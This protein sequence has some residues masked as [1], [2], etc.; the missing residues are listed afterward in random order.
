MD[1]LN[2]PLD[3]RVALLDQAWIQTGLRAS[4]GAAG[5]S[6][7]K[8]AKGVALAASVLVVALARRDEC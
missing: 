6:G 8:G 4:G 7:V 3:G 2:E 1:G 5:D